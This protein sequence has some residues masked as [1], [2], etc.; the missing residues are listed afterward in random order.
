MNFKE[1]IRNLQDVNKELQQRAVLAVNIS[2]TIRNWL[3][4]YYIVEFEQQGKDRADYG[5]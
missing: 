5:L 2:L 1:L 4:G 3:F